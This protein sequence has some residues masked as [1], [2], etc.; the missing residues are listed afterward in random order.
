MD[1]V[2]S[3]YVTQWH[4]FAPDVVPYRVILTSYATTAIK[5]GFGFRDANWGQD[6]IDYY[7]QDGTLLRDGGTPVT[8]TFVAVN[9]RRITVQVLGDSSAATAVYVAFTELL[10]SLDA[11]FRGASVLSLTQETSCVAQ[12]SFD[13][14]ALLNPA[15]VAHVDRQVRTLST[16]AMTKELKGVNLRFSI[17]TT[18]TNDQLR[19]YG[20]FIND[21]TITVEPRAYAPLSERLYFTYSP[22]DSDTHLRLLKQLEVNL[23]AKARGGGRATRPRSHS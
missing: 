12:L 21:Q 7:F 5:Q 20:A 16:D 8:I 18:T 3:L 9:D 4:L 10:E 6:G 13:W 23:S 19:Q 22:C 14:K 1:K 15:L 2:T 11:S 17:G